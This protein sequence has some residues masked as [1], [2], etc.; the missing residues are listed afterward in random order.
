M[1]LQIQTVSPEQTTLT[2]SLEGQL[3]AVT[4]PELDQFIS[5]NLN[6]GITTLI[7][8]LGKLNFVS[9]AGLR[10]FAKTR[11]AMQAQEGNFALLT[12]VPRCRRFSRLSKRFP[13][14]MS[15]A[16]WRNWTNIWRP[17]NA[18]LARKSK[19]EFV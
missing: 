8:D 10:I 9:S 13:T 6:P 11:K 7:L 14:Q 19:F 12:S 4:A 18:R 16:I 2:V 1:A 17:C 3:D 15:S 5:A